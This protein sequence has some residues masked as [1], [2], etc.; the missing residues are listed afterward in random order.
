MAQDHN[1]SS[2]D[3]N[4]LV[5]FLPTTLTWRLFDRWFTNLSC[6]SNILLQQHC[7]FMQLLIQF[8]HIL[9]YVKDVVPHFGH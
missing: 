9:T 6:L 4:E 8:R 1:L 7:Y 5:S 2:L 3:E